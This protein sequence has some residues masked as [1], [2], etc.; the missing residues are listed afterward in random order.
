MSI[1]QIYYVCNGQSLGDLYI[2]T[3]KNSL[4]ISAS[5]ND[6]NESS[7]HSPAYDSSYHAHSINAIF[8][9]VNHWVPDFHTR[10]RFRETFFGISPTDNVCVVNGPQTGSN[11]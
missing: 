5:G 6:T 4:Q 8:S 9:H 10:F 1:S 7:L 11:L 2:N 3:G